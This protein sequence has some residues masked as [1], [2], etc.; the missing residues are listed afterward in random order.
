MS[1]T[2][3]LFDGLL[4]MGRKYQQLEQHHQAAHVLGR[5]ARFP[6]LPPK[7]AEEAQLRLAELYLKR[8]KPARAR[9][10]LAALLCLCPRNA[11]YHLLMATAIQKQ[12]KDPERA[13]RYFRKALQLD[14]KQPDCLAAYGSC[15]VRIGNAATGLVHL[16]AAAEL[17]PDDAGVIG[18]LIRG[19]RRAG[20]ADEARC[21]LIAARF[22]NPRDGRFRRLYNDFM[23]GRLRRAQAR[24]QRPPDPADASHATLL[25]FARPAGKADRGG[26]ELRLI[27]LDPA[28]PTPAPHTSSRPARRSNR[29]HG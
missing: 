23:F 4:V 10:H 15:L 2:L 19:L 6:D 11:R 24:D 17:A 12:K 13:L 14:P 28:S 25:P 3:N 22:R 1:K 7:L 21:V 16:R 29:K 8:K 27:R 9:R 5:L 20:A 26:A 18:K